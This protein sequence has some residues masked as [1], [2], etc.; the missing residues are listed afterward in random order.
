MFI[1]E[2]SPK[3]GSSRTYTLLFLRRAKISAQTDMWREAGVIHLEKGG[4]KWREN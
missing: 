4:K 1:E 3:K 2:I